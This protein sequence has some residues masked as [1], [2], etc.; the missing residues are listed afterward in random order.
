MVLDSS[1]EPVP[2]AII[3]QIKA[4]AAVPANGSQTRPAHSAAGFDG[5]D[6]YAWYPAQHSADG[7]TLHEKD[8]T[9]ARVR[10][11]LRNDPTARSAIERRVDLLVGAGLRL[12]A[13]PDGAAL[14]ISDPHVLREL[15]RA[16][17]REWRL[18]SE[19]PRYLCDAQR[20]MSLN[21]IFRLMGRTFGTCGEAT[22]ALMWRD[23]P[24][25]RYA[26]CVMPIDPDRLC[27]PDGE[28]ETA[29][30]RGGVEMD[31]FGAPVAYHVRNAHVGDWWDGE[32]SS[33]WTRVPRETQWGRPIFIHG[34]EPER[35]GQTRAISPFAA[36][37]SQ[38]RMVGKFAD[39]EL[40]SA[41]A[42]ALFA[43]FVESDLP[44]AEVAQR[45]T[46]SAPTYADRLVDFYSKNPPQVGGVRIPVMLPGSKIT[47]NSSP[48]QTASFAAFQTAFLQK[49]AAA[50]GLSYEQLAMD[51]SNTNYSSC[52]AALNEVWRSVR[53]NFAIFVE[54]VVQPIYFAF[55]EEVFDRGY[56]ALPAG[57]APVGFG[58][59]ADILDVFRAMPGAFTRSHWIGP[60]RGYVDP[61]KES[62]AASMRMSNLTSTL[63]AE[64]AEQGAD[65][66]DVLDQLQIEADELKARGLVRVDVAP[67]AGRPAEDDQGDKPK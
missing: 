39:H 43:A 40:A 49:I 41:A 48:R 58:R 51:F 4:S 5:Q 53:K 18:F 8:L 66:E 47:M 55:L 14:G 9:L 12:S 50:L 59:G 13:K 2:A 64:C 21:G 61:V 26:M 22:A 42:N 32:R 36:L 25:R 3:E 6:T 15:S 46:P 23:A 38:L 19:D 16:I 56:V 52:R 67:K 54:Q 35:E 1:G 30:L 37:L 20:R 29:R 7:A 11:V 10:D 33:S 63:E 34:F 65:Y 31:R 57:A 27:N 62:Q 45:M 24:G 44:V 17:E 60:G 28:P